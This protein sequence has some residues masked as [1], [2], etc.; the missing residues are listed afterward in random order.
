MDVLFFYLLGFFCGIFFMVV[1]GVIRYMRSPRFVH[2][3]WKHS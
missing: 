1:V 3:L 2:D